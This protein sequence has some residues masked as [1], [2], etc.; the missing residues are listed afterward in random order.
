MSSFP[1]IFSIERTIVKPGGD[2]LPSN[3]WSALGRL[4][5]PRC[6]A[7]RLYFEGYLP[8]IEGQSTVQVVVYRM[9]HLLV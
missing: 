6:E 5:K 4:V 9:A 3:L 7:L 1:V 8:E 2:C